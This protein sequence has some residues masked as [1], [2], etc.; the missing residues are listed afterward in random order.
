MDGVG[1]PAR[2]LGADEYQVLHTRAHVRV[3]ARPALLLVVLGAAVGTG[4]ALVPYDLR[5]GVQAAVLGVGLLLAGPLVVRPFLRWL[6]TTYTLT[7]RRFVLRTGVL[8][9]SRRDVALARVHDVAV[10]R[11]L[12]DRLLG[13][14]TLQIVGGLDTPPVWLAHVPQVERVHA[15]V[16]DLL[17]GPPRVG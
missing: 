10:R 16:S 5:P 4:A 8:V 17:Y 11:G 12:L 15:V 1:L 14:G 2:L 3:L 9:R 13:T 6:S 7:T